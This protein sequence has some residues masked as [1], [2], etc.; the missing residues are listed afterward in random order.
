MTAFEV[1]VG[2]RG[3]E[4][5]ISKKARGDDKGGKIHKYFMCQTLALIC[6]DMFSISDIS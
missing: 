3:D 5:K 1:C 2:Q 6:R 4:Q